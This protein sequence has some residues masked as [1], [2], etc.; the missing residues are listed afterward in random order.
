MRI[1]VVLFSI[2]LLS[3]CANK[4]YAYS[5]LNEIEASLS[6]SG[7]SLDSIV[8]KYQ[9]AIYA[10]ESLRDDMEINFTTIEYSQPDSLGNQYKVKETVGSITHESSHNKNFNKKSDSEGLTVSKSDT[11]SAIEAIQK[12]E[13]SETSVKEATTKY[14]LIIPAILIALAALVY[15]LW[16]YI[17]KLIK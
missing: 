6:L 12:T 15:F 3:G 16:P 8:E 7:E 9:E 17:K 2:S 13:E 14:K 11:S 1:F 5:G 4:R 10:S